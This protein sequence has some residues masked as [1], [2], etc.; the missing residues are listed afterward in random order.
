M[1]VASAGPYASLHQMVVVISLSQNNNIFCQVLNCCFELH[2]SLLQELH[3]HGN[4]LNINIS[5][6]S[7]ATCFRYGGIFK[8]D[9]VATLLLSLKVEEF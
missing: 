6:G 9:F 5:Q 1:A 4:F 8:G 3:K 2:G 7:V